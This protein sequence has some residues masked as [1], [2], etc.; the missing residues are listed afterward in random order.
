MR[1]ILHWHAWVCEAKPVPGIELSRRQLMASMGGLVLGSYALP[2]GLRKLLDD[3]PPAM[4]AKPA[5]SVL[6]EIK[7]VVI[8]MQENRS[9]DHYFGVMPGVQG[10]ADSRYAK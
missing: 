6:K 10:F 7:H 2:P 5:S 1:A 9:F 3:V 8:L 4:T